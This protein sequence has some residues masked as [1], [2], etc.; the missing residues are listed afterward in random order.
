MEELENTHGC[1]LEPR[2]IPTFDFIDVQFYESFSRSGK[3]SKSIYL[4]AKI[5]G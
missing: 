5:S 3:L 1:I 2:T 4:G